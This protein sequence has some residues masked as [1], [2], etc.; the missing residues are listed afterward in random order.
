MTYPQWFRALSRADFVHSVGL[1]ITPER[2]YLVRLRKNMTNISIVEAESRE[3]P[4]AEDPAARNQ[5]L[6]DALRSLVHF[7]PVR[8][9]LHICLSSDQVISLE[10][11]LPQVAGD[12]I[13]Q[14]VNYE[15]ER[16]IPF[17][18]E[19]V[20]YDYV[21]TGAKGEKVGVL[22]F[23]AQKKLVDGVLE[24]LAGF[25]AKPKSVGASA[26]S[27]ANY[28][29]YCTGGI[30]GHALLLGGQNHDWEITAIDG[31]DEGWRQE[32]VMAFS[33]RLPHAEWVQG[34]GRELFYSA[35]R[36]SPRFFGWG[37]AGEFLKTVSE[38]PISYEDLTELG[39]QKL[40]AL[41]GVTADAAFLPAVGAALQ[42]LRE[43]TFGVNL[44]PGAKE[45]KR[46]RALSWLN[47][48]LAVML[49]VVLLAWMLSYP[50]K[51]EMRLRRLQNE[52]QKLNP[53]VDALLREET[54][55]NRLRKEI[56]FYNDLKMKR[57]LVM[58][59]LDELSRIVPTSAY[60]SNLR[61]REG[62]IELQGS[63]ENASSL[64]PLLERSPV[65]ENVAFNAPST[66]GRDGKQTFSIKADI[67]KPK[68]GQ[69]KEDTKAQPPQP[70]AMKAQ[71]S[72]AEAMKAQPSKTDAE[73]AA[74]SKTDAKD[75]P[76]KNERTKLPRMKRPP[77][78]AET[79]Q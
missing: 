44:L 4:T 50:I 56:A 53:S 11:S 67:E 66:T 49:A 59:I 9:P 38:E 63:A 79:K 43:A 71:P 74:P 60:V 32:A 64:I 57:G 39:K 48:A 21:P 47:S 77:R 25:G 19:D 51:D 26:I 65:F 31:R 68:P 24:V 78:D 13:S 3:I 55:L 18:R 52:N 17:R 6:A 62:T 72:Q 42:G 23:A 33:H 41:D 37:N 22:L 8:D 7:N 61:Y 30:S 58:R 76:E 27:L 70:E 12:N 2:F 10:M 36:R 45:Q 29:L 69:A 40:G 1:Y 14:V 5:A 15:I 54:E 20:Y 46:S 75:S 34:P 35:L 73:K 28:L 16:Y